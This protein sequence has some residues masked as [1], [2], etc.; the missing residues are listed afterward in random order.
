MTDEQ[1]EDTRNCLINQPKH[2]VEEWIGDCV[3]AFAVARA[4]Y[5]L[6]SRR[7]PTILPKRKIDAFSRIDLIGKINR[8]DPIHLCFQIKRASIGVPSTLVF[9]EDQSFKDQSEDLQFLRRDMTRFAEKYTLRC[10]PMI[11]WV[12]DDDVGPWDIRGGQTLNQLMDDL[13]EYTRFMD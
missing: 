3:G 2:V 8:F 6:L 1:R 9:L 11:L 12:G 7:V 13:I 10:L 5:Q 4:A